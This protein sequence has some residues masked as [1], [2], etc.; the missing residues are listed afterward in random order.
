MVDKSIGVLMGIIGLA[1]LAVIVSKRSNTA[2]V[3]TAFLTG[4]QRSVATAISPVV[5]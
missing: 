4:F 1:A 5:K 2:A 3:L